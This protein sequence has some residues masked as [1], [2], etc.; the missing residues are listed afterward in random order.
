MF[1]HL[2]TTIDNLLKKRICSAS[3][4]STSFSS[5]IIENL[6]LKIQ[7]DHK[8]QNKSS[9]EIRRQLATLEQIVKKKS[10]TADL[11]GLYICL[12]VVMGMICLVLWASNIVKNGIIKFMLKLQLRNTPRPG[13]RNAMRQEG[14][15]VSFQEEEDYPRGRARTCVGTQEA[16][17]TRE[18]QEEP[19]RNNLPRRQSTERSR[20]HSDGHQSTQ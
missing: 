3:Q 11:T 17:F 18:T 4:L 2:T 14:R 10:E 1:V 15:L 13:S 20:P 5:T 7:D 6:R 9:I 12:G 19:T 16:T 8:S